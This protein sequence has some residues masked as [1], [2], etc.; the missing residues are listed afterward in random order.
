MSASPLNLYS[1][2]DYTAT[3][4][5][6]VVANYAGDSV[7]VEYRFDIADGPAASSTDTS[8]HTIPAGSV[9]ESCDIFVE[10][11]LS[12]GTGFDL[13]LSQ[14]SGTVI[15]AD[16]L[17]AAVAATTGYVSGNGALVGTALANDGQLTLGGSRTAGALKVV[18]KYKKA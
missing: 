14:P 3:K 9:I 11:T 10:S 5:G 6:Q 2:D 16:G 4:K 13:G 17:D 7:E 18:I 15:D 8:V 12:G 1:V